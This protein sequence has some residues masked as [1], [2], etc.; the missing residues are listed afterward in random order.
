M[1]SCSGLRYQRYV[2]GQ[3]E[4]GVGVPLSFVPQGEDEEGL[5]QVHI[6]DGV[7]AVVSH[8]PNGDVVV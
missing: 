8:F 2:E 7:Y 6:L 5:D 4:Q 3:L 1:K